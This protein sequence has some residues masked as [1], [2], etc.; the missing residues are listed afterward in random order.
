[1]P[2]KGN[3]L[4]KTFMDDYLSGNYL[5]AS[6]FPQPVNVRITRAEIVQVR[7][8]GG[9]VPKPAVY[10]EG[11]QKPLLLNKTNGRTLVRITETSDHT[12]WA[13]NWIHVYSEWVQFGPNQVQGVRIR[14]PDQMTS[15]NFQ[16]PVGLPPTPQ[17]GRQP[18]PVQGEVPVRSM[19]EK[20]PPPGPAASGA[21]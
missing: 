2:E 6:D 19:P 13:G 20:T 7:G 17:A 1:M 14:E 16:R 21:A 18:P 3:P 11:Y 10:L 15:G 4:A 12:Q 8:D 9:E 5:S